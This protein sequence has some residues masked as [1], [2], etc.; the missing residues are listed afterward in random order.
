MDDG[1]DDTPIVWHLQ[2]AAVAHLRSIVLAQA[3]AFVCLCGFFVASYSPRL[4]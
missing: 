4:V 2:V 1:L 3:A